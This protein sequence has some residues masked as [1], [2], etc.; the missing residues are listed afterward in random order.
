MGQKT[1]LKGVTKAS[2]FYENFKLIGPSSSIKP[3]IR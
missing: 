3:Q 1:N 2:E